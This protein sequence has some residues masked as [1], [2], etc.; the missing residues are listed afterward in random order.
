MPDPYDH[1]WSLRRVLG[2]PEQ[3]CRVCSETRPY[4]VHRPSRLQ[5]MKGN[6][7]RPGPLVCSECGY[8]PNHAVHGVTPRA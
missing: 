7:A 2:P 1:S 8:P 4:P 3:I 6:L 5:P